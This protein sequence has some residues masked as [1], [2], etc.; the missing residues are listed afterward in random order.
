MPAIT[1]AAIGAV[2]AAAGGA[3]GGALSGK[4]GGFETPDVD[5]ALL[6]L[7]V[8][9]SPGTVG[10]PAG[11]EKS[12]R[13]LLLTETGFEKE[14]IPNPRRK[15]LLDQIDNLNEQIRENDVKFRAGT[16]PEKEGGQIFQDLKNKIAGLEAQLANEPPTIPKFIRRTEAAQ[17]KKAA[18]EA[19]TKRF[20]GIRD[21]LL[22][23][24][25]F[26]EVQTEDGPQ[27]QFKKTPADLKRQEAEQLLLDRQLKALRGELPVAPGL[28]RDLGKQ[29][30]V[31]KEQLR[32]NLGEGFATSSP[33]IE[34]LANFNQRR[35]E[36]LEAAR[37]GDIQQAGE[38]AAQSG[39][40]GG[41]LLQ[42]RLNQ[43]FATPSL[44]L[45]REAFDFNK[46]LS[47]LGQLTG[48]QAIDTQ[49][50]FTQGQ[51]TNQRNVNL[52][53]ALAQ[54]AASQLG[55]SVF[56]PGQDFSGT[57]A[58]LGGGL[59]RLLGQQFIPTPSITPRSTPTAVGGGFSF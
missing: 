33:G 52:Q 42:Q 17:E 15:Q 20:A 13:D 18:A 26:E 53:S 2:G 45:E 9:I 38:L 11:F 34:A 35:N 30:Q 46:L 36:V 22:K 43:L 29:Q 58:L 55:Q 8:G 24:L 23:E 7:L 4:G 31:L 6:N 56:T 59:G 14:D 10:F 41:N 5:P 50:R 19:E 48:Q 39:V 57:G 3:A 27:F 49:G 37:R 44:G 25:G 12:I 1:A 51:L 40:T 28:L 16:I 47:T 54:L 21:A 32:R